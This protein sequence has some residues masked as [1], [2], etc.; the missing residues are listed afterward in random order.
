M[1]RVSSF[2][3]PVSRTEIPCFLLE[4]LALDTLPAGTQHALRSSFSGNW[5]LETGNCFH[6]YGETE[7]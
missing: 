6:Q 3:F 4:N 1:K 5:K 7:P 2:Q